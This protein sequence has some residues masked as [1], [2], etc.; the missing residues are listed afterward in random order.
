MARSRKSS[1]RSGRK[2]SKAR[3]RGK[4]KRAAAKPAP[5]RSLARHVVY[6]GAV[7]AI[8]LTLIVTGLVVVFSLTLPDN[9]VASLDKRPPNLSIVA[10]DGTVL[11]EHLGSGLTE[12]QRAVVP[13]PCGDRVGVR[14]QL[15]EGDLV[16]EAHAA[17]ARLLERHHDGRRQGHRG[18]RE[19]GEEG[20][21]THDRRRLSRAPP[22]A[23]PS[24][25]A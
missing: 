10:A 18:D 16:V 3:T 20:L 23:G 5:H 22:G 21:G 24:G 4:G 17:G 13:R 25:P 6:W 12:E 2:P 9:V 8:W 7:A 14:A 15:R 19:P 11:A 1:E